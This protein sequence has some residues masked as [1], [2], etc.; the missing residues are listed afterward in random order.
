M[1]GTTVRLFLFVLFLLTLPTVLLCEVTLI[2]NLNQRHGGPGP[3][4]GFYFASCW[5][6]VAPDGHEYALIGCYSGTSIIDL[7][8]NPIAEV[9]YIPGA[10]SEWKELKTWGNYAYAVSE[11]ASQGIQIIN[12]SQLPDTAWLV[13]SVFSVG[14]HNTAYTHTVTADDGFLYLNGGSSNGTVI[15]SL[16]DP[17][18]PT[19]AGQYQPDYLHDT[20]VKNDTLYG[21]AIYGGGVYIA[22]VKVK[23]A[24]QEIG[25][26]TYPNAGTH[27][28]WKSDFGS[29]VFTTDEI[30]STQKNMKV[31][32]ISGAPVQL[33]PFTFDPV[34]VIHNVHGRGNYVYVA[35]YAAGVFVADVHDPSNITNAGGYDT[36]PG[37]GGYVGSWGGY[38]YFPS[39]RWIASDTQTGLYLLGFSGAV[40][41]TRSTLLSP[42]N[43]DT[44]L[45]GS[46]IEFIWKEVADP[47]E[48]PHYFQ[49]HVFG[50]GVDTLVTATDTTANFNPTVAFQPGEVYSWH[51]WIK[52]Q[53]TSV[54]SADTLQFIYGGSAFACG[55]IFFFNARCNANGAAQAMVK[56]TGDLT[57]E[58]V[59]F[60]LDGDDYIV[61]VLSNGTNSIAKMIVPHAGMGSHTVTLEDPAGC[62]SPVIINCQVD[63]PPDPEWDALWAEYDAL[64]AQALKDLPTETRIIGN[65]PNP[66]NPSTTF[67]YGLRE[68]GQV[69]LKVYNMLGQLVRTIVDE[70]QVEGYH[71]ALWDGRNEIGATVASGIY[72]YRMTAGNFVE[73]KRMILMK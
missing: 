53:F 38:R 8:A 25:H 52:D 70:Q 32:D 51:V 18:N 69:S 68:P 11:N 67:R 62:Y 72:V 23:S 49:V 30:G 42:M 12:L 26:I 7:D 15:L 19:Y 9:A 34:N 55:D 64:E 35:H 37:N 71:E 22:D 57:G 59:T 58:T 31:F 54:S 61:T 66:F 39:G 65:Y 6:Y 50:P 2:A 60:D 73:T 45:E 36:Y 47:L 44:V 27:N 20:Y 28:T 1:P 16:A 43:G 14:G 21:A 24:V 48:D 3:N 5:G 10:N 17:E 33:T 4:F 41:R 13:R 56:M 63:A 46:P 40:P 29:Y